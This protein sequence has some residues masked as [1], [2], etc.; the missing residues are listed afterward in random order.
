MC[1]TPWQY[2]TPFYDGVFCKEGIITG[3]NTAQTI[4][5][6]SQT[7]VVVN[8]DSD[9]YYYPDL[10]RGMIVDEAN[11]FGTDIASYT[12]STTGTARNNEICSPFTPITWQV[13]RKCHII[14]AK[15][16]D[17]MC[18]QM[19]AQADN[20]SDDLYAHGS[21]ELVVPEHAANNQQLRKRR[22]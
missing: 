19:K 1:N 13:D 15:S 4:G 9:T 2:Q 20:L 16:F 5:V 10:F 21:R 18:A 7:F 6:Q 11:E 22:D 3:T 17:E 12:G 8:D 14:N